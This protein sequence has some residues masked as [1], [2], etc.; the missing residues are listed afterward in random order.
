MI[1][2]LLL[3]NI[4]EP[5]QIEPKYYHAQENL[6]TACLDFL[7]ILALEGVFI[8]PEKTEKQCV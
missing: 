1:K 6:S 5:V 7:K 3:T 2:H 8:W 4:S